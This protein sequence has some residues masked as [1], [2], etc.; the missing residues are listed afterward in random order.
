MQYLPH[1]ALQQAGG[2]IFRRL[3][4]PRKPGVYAYAAGTF[5]RRDVMA[6][7]RPGSAAC[8]RLW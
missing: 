8:A 5:A 7:G 3:F 4:P 2:C 6:R 1:A